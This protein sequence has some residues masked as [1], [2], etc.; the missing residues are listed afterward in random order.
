MR[1]Y[2]RALVLTLTAGAICPGPV[3]AQ[4]Q[5]KPPVAIIPVPVDPNEQRPLRIS[6]VLVLGSTGAS[7]RFVLAVDALASTIV[8]GTWQP[9]KAGEE[10]HLA[11]GAT[12]AWKVSKLDEKGFLKDPDVRGGWAY[13]GVD[14]A[15]DGVVILDARGHGMVYVNGEPRAGDPY[16]NGSVRL[17]VALRAGRNHLLFKGGRAAEMRVLLRIPLVPFEFD[18]AEPTLPDLVVGRGGPM[19]GAVVVTNATNQWQRGWV[20]LA[21]V[22]GG[23]KTRT[24]VDPVPPLSTR[25]IGFGFEVPDGGAEKGHLFLGLA[26]AEAADA[27]PPVS[28][29]TSLDIR[30]PTDVRKVT[31]R[32]GIDGSVQYY[33][34]R[35]AATESGDL[36]GLPLIISLHGAGVEAKGQ[37]A[38]Y[39]GK[40]WCNVVA[41][42]NR[43]AFGFDWEDWGRVDA[44]EVLAHAS[45][46]LK[47]DPRRTYLTGHSMGGHGTWQIGAHCPGLFAA[48]GPSAGWI[49]FR[50][51]TGAAAYDRGT[52]V[53][54]ILRRAASPSDTLA[55][56][57]NYFQN[58]VFI[59]HGDA[60]DNVPVTQA[61]E[62]RKQLGEFHPD[63]VYREQPGA[64]HWWGNQCVDWPP[65]MQFFS[66]RSRPEVRDVRRVEFVTASPGV[67]AACDWAIIE[68]QAEQFKPSS[69][70]IRLDAGKR[71][72]SGTTANVAR[73]SLDLA[74]LS[75]LYVEQVEDKEVERRVLEPGKPI[76]VVLDGQTVSDIP[77]PEVGDRV[78]LARAA[79]DGTSWAVVAK[80]AAAAKGPRRSGLFKTAF[81]NNAVLVVG[82]AGTP[83]ETAWAMA[84]ARYDAE[85][86][87]YRGN[88]SFQIMLDTEFDPGREP[89]RSVIL[90]GSAYSNRA[91]KGLLGD[92]P[93]QVAEGGITVGERRL[94][95]EDLAC[96]L[97]R[98]RPGSDTASVGAVGGTGIAGMRLASLVP[99]F[100]SGV[101]IPDWIVI[102]PEATSKGAGGIRAAGFFGNDWELSERDSGWASA[103]APPTGA[104][105]DP[106]P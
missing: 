66:D 37:A 58:G 104:A 51:Y 41:P 96:L 60:D 63:F 21:N 70:D 91:W 52:P 72:F 53:E 17:P 87:W 73:L 75:A 28:A 78:W 49:S 62:M 83:E 57:R 31:F 4:D 25:K 54:N 86:F 74:A 82:T 26:R 2:L 69:I 15:E 102:G 101:A 32:S 81:G 40:P 11:S 8:D 64:G 29:V 106:A 44:M 80:P 65:M 35:P 23:P 18:M 103:P 92:S 90:Y 22:A 85:T 56:K 13:V 19:L 95:G 1:S 88:G 61:R 76:S 27:P 97:I 98:P 10:V 9:P 50:S 71:L 39:S 68:A 48:I 6:E 45:A 24:P 94:M 100:V 93:V 16:N 105:G 3:L 14:A 84:K 33:A 42:T 36:T 79:A 67:S 7:G 55:L 30:S 99:Y 34:L 77:W 5:P 47:P 20:L 46:M 43:R 59:L 38:C 89:D 12:R